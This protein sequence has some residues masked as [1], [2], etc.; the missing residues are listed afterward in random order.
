MSKKS[1]KYNYYDLFI[2]YHPD[3]E[4]LVEHV[5]Q[6]FK[7][8][9]FKIWYDKDFMEDRLNRFDES[10][11]ALRRSFLFVCFTTKKYEKNIQ[12]KIE[13]LTAAEE[14]MNIINLKLEDFDIR[15]AKDLDLR[16]NVT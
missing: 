9:N 8:Y 15:L 14:R 10:L 4:F 2:S 1:T 7:N 13:Y 5:C 6:L 11:H 12:C 3:D 16:K